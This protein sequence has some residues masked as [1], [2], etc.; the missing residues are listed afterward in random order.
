MLDIYKTVYALFIEKKTPQEIAENDEMS[1]I[2]NEVFSFDGKNRLFSRNYEYL[3]QI[4]DYNLRECWSRVEA[5]VLSMWG[6]ADVEV[7][8]DSEHKNIV[9]I[10]NHYHSG[11]AEF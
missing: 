10:V 1:I 6:S 3:V 9:E 7:Y 11:K 5:N 8:S 2:L 4:D